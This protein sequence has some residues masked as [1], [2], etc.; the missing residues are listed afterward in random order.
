MGLVKGYTFKQVRPF[1]ESLRSTGY[2][3]DICFFYSDLDAETTQALAEY[4]ITLIPFR[5][6]SF[7]A[8][9]KQ[10]N[11]FALLNRLYKSSL[12]H[13]LNKVFV[14]LTNLLASGNYVNKCRIAAKFLNVYCVRFPLYY[15]YLHHNP[16]YS[17]VTIADVRDVLFQRDPFSFQREKDL[18]CFLEDDRTAIKNC[19]FNRAW[20]TEGFGKD[21]LHKV[22]DNVISCSGVTIGTRTAMMG[23]LEQMVDHMLRLKFHGNGIDQGVHNYIL[24]NNRVPEVQ[25]FKNGRGP[26]L[27]MGRTTDLPNRFDADGFLLNDDGTVANVLHQYDRH[28]EVG[29]LVFEDAENKLKPASAE[30]LTC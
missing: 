26:V 8:G 11:L 15:V 18:A 13:P 3:G 1:V 4:Q 19:E 28:V 6:G 20:I 21:A 9:R 10:L 7:D 29:S 2:D 30:R 24:Y 16:Q 14:G 22:G 27:T 12:Q 23:Y 17:N 5:L 25:L